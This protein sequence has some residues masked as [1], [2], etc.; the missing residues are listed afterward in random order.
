MKIMIKSFI[1]ILFTSKVLAASDCSEFVDNFK[2]MQTA[3]QSIQNSTAENYDIITN[4]Y[5]SL[6]DILTETS[7]R[8]YK[9][10]VENM[11]SSKDQFKKRKKKAVEISAKF[12]KEMD[13][14]LKIAEKC[15]K[16][17]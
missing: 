4:S 6:A 12:D 2:Q 3:Q 14:M 16:N 10:V 13:K 11:R 5:D 9:K 7:G 15:I 17:Q 8:A 1:V